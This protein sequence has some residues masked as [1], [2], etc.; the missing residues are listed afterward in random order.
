MKPEK[1]A[2]RYIG[3]EQTIHAEQSPVVERTPA[4]RANSYIAA[5]WAGGRGRHAT[6]LDQRA[7]EDRYRRQTGRANQCPDDFETALDFLTPADRCRLLG[8]TPK[9]RRRSEKKAWHGDL[10]LRARP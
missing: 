9:Q 6:P 5:R 2:L 10:V 3:K 1:V 8:L 4:A 7:R